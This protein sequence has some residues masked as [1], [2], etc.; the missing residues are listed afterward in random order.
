MNGGAVS[1]ETR[2]LTRTFGNFV[3]VDR[4]SIRVGRGEIFGFLGANGAGKTTMIRMLCGLLPPTGGEA[5]VAGLDVYRQSEE[6][7]QNIGYMSQKFSL[8]GDLTVG[9]NITFY[10]GIYGLSRGQIR[11]KREDLLSRFELEG[12]TLTQGLPLGF[13]QRLALGCAMLHEPPILFLDEPTSGVDPKARR[14][15]WDLIHQ[16]AAGGTTVFVT[17]HFMDE[18]EYCQRVSVM[19]AGRVIALDTPGR[20][21][22]E[23]GKKSMQDVFVA[24]VNRQGR[25]EA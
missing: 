23:Y 15:F 20:L 5:M 8:Y 22:Q 17:T 14:G 18:A 3:A 24:L 25:E 16:A 7:K 19:A 10:G 1:V 6:I 21:K 11:E 2:E 13:K 4:V 9:E 12:D